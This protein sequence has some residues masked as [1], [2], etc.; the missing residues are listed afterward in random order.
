MQPLGNTNL[1]LLSGHIALINRGISPCSVIRKYILR[2]EVFA[3][4]LS[5]KKTFCLD[6]LRTILAYCICS[7]LEAGLAQVCAAHNFPVFTAITCHH[8]TAWG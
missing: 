6:Y 8:C 2:S 3:Q 1:T 4:G 5:E 7:L